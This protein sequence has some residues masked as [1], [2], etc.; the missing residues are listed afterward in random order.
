MVLCI[1]DHAGGAVPR[2]EL[3]MTHMERALELARSVLGTT[4]PNPSVGAV[5]VKNG[6][7]IGRGA[8]LPPGQKHAEI[9]ALQQAGNAARGS[10]LYTT[11]E[12]CCTFGRTPPCTARASS[13]QV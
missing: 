12:P 10:T 4:S 1:M 13:T 6:V 3:K 2:P 11:L 7:E 8:T 9:N 5:V